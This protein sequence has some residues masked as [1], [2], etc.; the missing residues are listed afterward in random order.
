[1]Y[2]NWV[3]S[4]PN[5]TITC[6]MLSN[7]WVSIQAKDVLWLTQKF[8]SWMKMTIPVS[9]RFSL[10]QTLQGIQYQFIESGTGSTNQRFCLEQGIL[11]AI[12]NLEHGWGDYF[13]ARIA[14]QTN[15]VAVPTWVLLQ[16]AQNALFLI[17]RLTSSHVFQSGTGYLFSR[18]CLEQGS[19]IVSGTG[20]GSRALSG[21]PP[22]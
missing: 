12:R 22:S 11:F 7:L 10:T 1:M 15:V 14:V 5:C 17:R 9:V 16:V 18:F 2:W 13:A 4:W 3:P 20:S 8:A 6:Y 21:T 19:R